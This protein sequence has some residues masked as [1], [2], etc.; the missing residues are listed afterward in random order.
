MRSQRTLWPS[1]LLLR[2]FP[3]RPEKPYNAALKGIARLEAVRGRPCEAVFA[4]SDFEPISQTRASCAGNVAWAAD[5]AVKRSQKCR[6]NVNYALTAM[7][8][9]S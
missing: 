3:A 6:K 8:N 9:R 2:N 1:E 5:Q 7:V 4:S